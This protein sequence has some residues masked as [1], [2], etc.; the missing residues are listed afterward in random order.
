[1]HLNAD[2][3]WGAAVYSDP[4][5]V[6]YTGRPLTAAD[7]QPILETMRE[8]GTAPTYIGFGPS[9]TAAIENYGYAPP[10][11]TEAFVPILMADPGVRL[12]YED[13]DVVILEVLPVAL[14]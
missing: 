3:N 2:G 12:V 6:G 13:G 5:F 14:P 11:S 7:V 10:G 4:H 1:M 9:Q 8:L